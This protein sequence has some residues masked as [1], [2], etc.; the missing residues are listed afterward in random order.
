MKKPPTEALFPKEFVKGGVRSNFIRKSSSDGARK[1]SEQLDDQFRLQ[2]DSLVDYEVV[3][4][5]LYIVVS[6]L[7]LL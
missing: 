4:S 3:S 6:F 2:V 7:G 1:V 5:S